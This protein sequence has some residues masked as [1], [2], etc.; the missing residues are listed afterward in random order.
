MSG[1]ITI[2]PPLRKPTVVVPASTTRRGSTIRIPAPREA[3]PTSTSPPS[4]P[5]AADDDEDE[6]MEVEESQNAV[7]DA[8]NDVQQASSSAQTLDMSASREVS[9]GRSTPAIDVEDTEDIAPRTTRG[10][11]R[12][13]PR[14]SR[15]RGPGR[16]RGGRGF[17]ARQLGRGDG[18]DGDETPAEGDDGA[19]RGPRTRVV[20]GRTYVIDESELQ[21]DG[22]PKGDLKIDADG[23]LLGGEFFLMYRMYCGT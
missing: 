1:R 20:A 17:S 22:D 3:S 13:R 6:V 11:P 7:I 21:I 2:K 9:E 5:P 16:A 19:T 12:G 4:D 18:D 23:N 15:A 10:R 14:G 8:S